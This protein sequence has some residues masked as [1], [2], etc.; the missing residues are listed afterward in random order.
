LR[1]IGVREADEIERG[2]TAFAR[3]PNSGLIV[4]SSSFANF[5]R[6]LI[7]SLAAKYQLPAVYYT[8]QFAGGGLI[9]YG[10][11]LLDGFRNA[12]RY[13]DRIFKGEQPGDLPVQAATK[14][15]MVIN[16]K[17]AKTLALTVPET[18]LATAD[19]VIQ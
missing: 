18:L 11:D 4:T 7:V 13:I 9:S 2:I 1:P 8:R 6:E 17:T 5:R 15:E 19:D 3:M 10:P 16:L 12:A 14:Y